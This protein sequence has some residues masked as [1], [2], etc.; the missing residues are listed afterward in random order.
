MLRRIL[1]VPACAFATG[2]GL[3]S[4]QAGEVT[5]LANPP[6]SKGEPADRIE[7]Y[8]PERA[9]DDGPVPALLWIDGAWN[10]GEAGG[11]GSRATGKSAPPPSGAQ[12]CRELAGAGYVC[13]RL[14]LGAGAGS[15]SAA[16]RAGWSAIGRLQSQAKTYHLDPTRIAVMGGGPGAAL[17]WRVGA[18]GAEARPEPDGPGA[19][20]GQAIRS[21]G[22]FYGA[23]AEPVPPV[24]E[25]RADC[26][27]VFL[28]EG[29]A[30]PR[31]DPAAA[32]FD[33]ALTAVGVPHALVRLDDG[34]GALA[35]A[36]GPRRPL[37]PE[38]DARLRDFLRLRLGAAPHGL[39]V[40]AARASP[41]VQVD[42]DAGWRFS[43]DDDPAF[44]QPEFD[45]GR[46]RTVQ[47]PHTWNARDGQDGGGDYRRGAGWYRRTLRLDP[48]LAGKRLYLQFD[49]V[50]LAA[51]VYVNGHLLGSHQGG[52]ARFRFDATDAL[53]PG[54]DN[55]IAVRVDNED[56]GLPPTSGDF[57]FF[58]G[59]Y[60]PVSLLATDQ[61][62]ISATDY[63][64]SGVFITQDQVTEQRAEI[65]VMAVLENYE[66]KARDLDVATRIEDAD[67][68]ELQTFTTRRRL[69]PGDSLESR[70]VFAVRQPH[71]WNGAADPYLYRVTVTL[72]NLDRTVRDAVS[73]PLGLRFYRVDPDRGFLLNGH[74][75]DLHGTARQQDRLNKGWA[76]T[77]ADEDEDF[78]LV[79]ELGA[80]SLR[81][82]PY[83]QT[84]SWY[85][86]CDRAGIVAWAEVPVIN[87]VS[88]GKPFLDNAK[89]Q[90]R[91]LIRQNYNHPA[92]C[93]WGI[94]SETRGDAADRVVG[95]LARVVKA[96]DPTRLST[97]ASDADDRDP[98]NWH[99]DVVGFNR[100]AGWY[101]GDIASLGPW[102]EGVHR[103]HPRAAFALS[104]YGA[105][106]SVSQ[107]EWPTMEPVAKG[108]FHPEEY[109]SLLHEGS[110]LAL[111]DRP[112]VW[113]KI[114]WTLCDFASDN[115]AEG[116][117]PG[118]NDKGLVTYDR[119][120]RKDAF[121]WYRA[122][123]SEAPTVHLNSAGWTTR[124]LPATE[125]RAYANAPAAEATLN[126][127]SLGLVRSADHIFRWPGVVLA[128]G[129][130]HVAVSA[131]FGA[132]TVTDGATWTYRPAH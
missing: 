78:A 54:V 40:V 107:H 100:Y 51:D 47:V 17:A 87:Q 7:L 2:F 42:L 93:F 130:N 18:I 129:D 116:D 79:R 50:S 72:T 85:D 113:N 60:R 71:L 103:R 30:D 123:W 110:W 12:I 35:A 120:T 126:G 28:A 109:Q 34:G 24:E 77:A 104:E 111:R 9:A 37:S 70:Q 15:G 106:A 43:E 31:A 127:R 82:C 23:G 102:L 56:L 95:D 57:T 13:A 29:F 3:A 84:Q 59:I 61:V 124:D 21:V 131:Q 25:I 118:R 122:N 94:G 48:T 1:A 119:R 108:N 8:L 32:A 44:A 99:T 121:Y 112:Y 38:P 53:R 91:E 69:Q 39:P 63:G 6:H 11:N 117:Q 5:V 90:L 75:F 49:G 58:G 41:R 115:R 83:Q 66:D 52:F 132:T 80:T 97:Y 55:V 96:E 14:E 92:I 22:M 105:G 128:P 67:G 98:R 114:V 20:V 19:A 101:T 68:K 64:S 81:I 86:R 73:Q 36:P 45:D 33:R 27:P 65:T 10:H 26:P 16:I 46:W 76:V 4:P 62:Q 88:A 74:P 125:I 89:Q